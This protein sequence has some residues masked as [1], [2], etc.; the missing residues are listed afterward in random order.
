MQPI[1]FADARA[2]VTDVANWY[3]P[4]MSLVA[5]LEKLID[6]SGVLDF[7]SSGDIV[8]VKTHFGDRGTTRI[9]RSVFLRKISEAIKEQGGKPFVTETTGLGLLRDRSTAVG[10]IEI[11]EENGITHQTAGAPVIV[12]DGLL[13]L[14]YVVAEVNGKHLKRVH[15]AKGIAE[16]DAVVVATHFKLHMRAGIGGSIKN[17]GVGCVAKPTKYDIHV[18]NP[19]RIIAEKCTECGKCVEVCPAN[20]IIDFQIDLNRCVKC[21][22]CREVCEYEA[23][24][25][26]PWLLGEEL[27]ERVV[28][29]TKGVMDVVGKENF[30]FLNFMIDVTPHCDCHP[31]SDSPLMSDVGV[32]A[33]KD[34]VAVDKA[35]L[36]KLV[37]S[38]KA[39]DALIDGFWHGTAPERQLSYAAELGLGSLSYRI[40]EV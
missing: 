35:C 34:I 11:A 28:E 30:A 40:T 17:I 31:F 7:I 23:V 21:T 20:A 33:S 14:D 6:E 12:A 4:E 37:E 26:Q 8:A 1:F 36:D 9:L 32:F 25:I 27:A 24:E 2:P 15:V 29:A 22:G 3:R 38:P 39:P 19:P 18:P 13:G 10:R 16:A 5:R